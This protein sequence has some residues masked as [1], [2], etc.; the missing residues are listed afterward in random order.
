MAKRPDIQAV[1]RLI[2]DQTNAFRNAN[3]RGQV[4]RDDRLNRVARSYARFL[5]R[6]GRF[7]HTADGRKPADRVVAGGYDYCQVAENLALHL[8]SRGFS[9]PQ[10]ARKAIE[11]W[12]KSPGHRRNMLA[13]HVTE[14]GVGV[15]KTKGKEQYI[16]VQVFARPR[17]ASY[18]FRVSNG[19]DTTIFY[20]TDA[21]GFTLRPNELATHGV[22]LPT[23]IAFHER[24]ARGAS[25]GRFRARRGDIFTVAPRPGGG[26]RV[27]RQR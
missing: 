15:A 19:S 24:S 5:A 6:T 18:E 4:K 9:T 20:S 21:Q 16:S 14:L 13:P 27:L 8:D 23:G 11:G 7:A 1:E 12:K 22:C 25:L 17:A 2:F 26:L 10:L 3:G